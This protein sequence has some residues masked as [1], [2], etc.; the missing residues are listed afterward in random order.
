MQTVVR[1]AT[2]VFGAQLALLAATVV[3][4]RL[5]SGRAGITAVMLLA[6]VNALVV[7]FVLMGLR[8][9]GRAPIALAV[10]TV[11]ITVGLLFWPAWDIA[12][13]APRWF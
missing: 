13:R 11:V 9:D 8:R 5:A 7:A 2:V 1:R 4:A 6:G 12:Y 3:V 10:L